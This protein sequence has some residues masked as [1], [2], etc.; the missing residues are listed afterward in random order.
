MEDIEIQSIQPPNPLERSNNDNTVIEN[1]P[2]NEALVGDKQHISTNK[3]PDKA[4]MR[5]S[6]SFY[7]C[8]SETNWIFSRFPGSRIAGVLNFCWENAKDFVGALAMNGED[9]IHQDPL[10]ESDFE[11]EPDFKVAQYDSKALKKHWNTSMIY[12]PLGARIWWHMKHGVLRRTYPMLVVFLIIYYIIS[13]F[14]LTQICCQSND[15]EQGLQNDAKIC[16]TEECGIV[17]AITKKWIV[18]RVALGN[19]EVPGIQYDNRHDNITYFCN[20]FEEFSGPWSEKEARLTRVLAFFVGF[21][22]SFVM[23]NWWRQAETFPNLD[24]M[25]LAMGSFVFVDASIDESIFKVRVG[26]KIVSI[27]QLKKDI[28][29]LALLSYSMCFCR[30]STRLKKKLPDAK[31]FIEKGLMTESECIALQANTHSGWLLKWVTPQLWINR[32]A[33]TVDGTSLKNLNENKDIKDKKGNTIKNIENLVK[34]M[35]PKQIGISL[36]KFKDDL[37]KIDNHY[38]F[39]M[40][41]LIRQV[42]LIALYFYMFLGAIGGQ[43]K[44]FHMKNDMNIILKLIT[45]FPMYYLIKQLLFIGWLIPPTDL[46]NPYGDDT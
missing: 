45:N 30:I 26:N 41:G 36:F 29:R 19:S 5:D 24:K 10:N 44:I 3:T 1:I 15:C 13:I 4:T 14:I 22:V 32:I 7:Q 40:P 17:N 11:L 27:L 21:Y 20:N 18:G 12:Q 43:G 25:S 42:I 37:Q 8:F 38:C 9:R 28:F 2:E 35:D 23:R 16:S 31:A 33:C 39:R 6:S 34:I 46:Q